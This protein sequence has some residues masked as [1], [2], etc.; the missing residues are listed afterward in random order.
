MRAALFVFLL[1]VLLPIGFPALA[2]ER[3]NAD[4]E[5]PMIRF[6]V[7][8]RSDTIEGDRL[9]TGVQEFLDRLRGDSGD[10]MSPFNVCLVP[11]PYPTEE[12]GYRDL[13]EIR[14]QLSVDIVIGPTDS[15]VFGDALREEE[16]FA[17][18]G[19]VVVSPVV[20]A[21]F[22]EQSDWLFK[23]NADVR[24]R[25]ESIFNFLR[26]ERARSIGVLY[27]GT[28]FGLSA[29]EAFRELSGE[30][31]WYQAARYSDEADLSRAIDVLLDERP[32]AI[33]ILASRKNVEWVYGAIDARNSSINPYKPYIFTIIDVRSNEIPLLDFVSVG[34]LEQNETS[35][36]T[37]ATMQRV[38]GVLDG[39]EGTPRSNP[40]W[41]E[42]VKDGL[43][44]V[45]DLSPQGVTGERHLFTWIAG[46]RGSVV[47]IEDDRQGS[48]RRALQGPTVLLRRFGALPILD[49]LIV[50]GLVVLL[51]RKD[52]RKWNDERHLDRRTKLAMT[53]VVVLN[54][55]VALTVFFFMITTGVIEWSSVTGAIVVG[56][57]YPALLKTTIGQTKTG[58]SIGVAD[59]YDDY[60]RR[61]N[62]DIMLAK[63]HNRKPIVDFIALTNSPARMRETLLKLYGY[64]SA[65]RKRELVQGLDV[66]IEAAADSL[67]LRSIYARRIY[68]THDWPELIDGKFVPPIEAD[69]LVGPEEI[70]QAAVEY[71]D[72]STSISL[73]SLRTDFERCVLERARD[74]PERAM[75]DRKEVE[76][77][78]GHAQTE[79]GDMRCYLRW[80]C[81][82]VR[83][84]IKKIIEL[85]YLPAEAANWGKENWN[86]YT[87]RSTSARRKEWVA[88]DDD[89]TAPP[90]GT[91][92]QVEFGQAA[93]PTSAEGDKV[94]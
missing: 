16:T 29:E 84:R 4:S 50:A 25:A 72:Q 52:L 82:Q 63:Y 34:T 36:L 77:W 20:A 45:L 91:D 61:L 49:L 74:H 64:N 11:Y 69:E 89:P 55:G 54:V 32:A 10:A 23:T 8:Y 59:I 81:T 67:D 68:R 17:T 87:S 35:V 26:T 7:L 31:E 40:G 62:D 9:L 76:E 24:A 92:G 75:A 58:V 90:D 60:L 71:S 70:L 51:T 93:S 73:A 53:R 3:C 48:I 37:E 15:G 88:P 65:K 13:K 78:L 14:D 27:E 18:A 22:E 28:A 33:G 43:A 12:R 41:A 79:V 39:V 85:H 57:G 86:R 44:G 83:F 1:P 5:S 66:E 80:L 19:L 94:G 30:L 2:V 56:F 47:D 42:D 38:L 21:D 6:G 46:E